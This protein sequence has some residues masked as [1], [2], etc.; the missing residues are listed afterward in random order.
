MSRRHAACT[1]AGIYRELGIGPEL[2]R[3][4]RD[5]LRLE[6]CVGLGYA[7]STQAELEY[8]VE[9]ARASGICLDPVYS[10]KAALGMVADLAARPVERALF[11]HTGGLLGLYAK[12]EMLKPILAGGWE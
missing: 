11:I 1:P 10:G 8:L 12:E 3:S 2:V 6:D 9:V 4:S 7:Q 5:L